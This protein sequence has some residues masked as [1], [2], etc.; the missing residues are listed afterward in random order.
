MDLLLYVFAFRFIAQTFEI[1]GPQAALLFSITLASSALG[2][3][4]FGVISDYVGRVKALTYSILIYS[5]FTM[6][7]AF[8]PNILFFVICRFLLGLGMGGEW[9]SGEILVAESWPKEHRGKVVGM[10]QSGWGFGFIF[11]AILATFVLP[12]DSFNLNQIPFIT[13]DFPIESWRVL[14]FLGVLPAFLVFYVRRVCEE[15]EVWK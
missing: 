4:V 13:T 14:F 1:S 8:A 2:G 5:L 3:M 9:A 10:V 7:S 15:P 12:I 6:L 11:A